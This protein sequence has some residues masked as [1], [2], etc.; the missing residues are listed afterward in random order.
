MAADSLIRKHGRVVFLTAAMAAVFV[1]LTVAVIAAGK[2]GQKVKTEKAGGVK[3]EAKEPEQKEMVMEEKKEAE[4][5]QVGS[6]S[7]NRKADDAKGFIFYELPEDFKKS[8]GR[9]PEAVQVYTFCLCLENNV[10]FGIV[11]AVIETESGYR[12]DAKSS[13]AYGYMQIVP[14]C[15]SERMKRLGVSDILDPYQNIMT[16]IDYLSEMLNK[17]DGN[18]KKALTAYRWGAKGAYRDYFSKGKESCAYA[19]IVIKRAERI[20]KQLGGQKK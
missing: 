3:L 20:K 6:M 12:R 10:E 14:S 9:L 17:F 18:Y 2:S 16:G 13:V 1:C 11:L 5:D 19:D 15:H 8:G 7:Q 4:Q